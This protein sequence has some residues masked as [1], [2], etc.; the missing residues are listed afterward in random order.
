MPRNSPQAGRHPEFDA[1]ASKFFSA[2]GSAARDAIY[3]EASALAAQVGPVAT[4]YLRVMEKVANGSEDYI[5]KE[6]KRYVHV[7]QF[8]FESPNTTP[9]T[10]SHRSY[11]SASYRPKNWMRSRPRR[12]SLQRLLWRRQRKKH[13]MHSSVRLR[14]CSVTVLC[15][16]A[17][18]R[19][20]DRNIRALL[21]GFPFTASCGTPPRTRQ[22]S[23]RTVIMDI[24]R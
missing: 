15:M 10:V 13:G 12:T 22:V 17:R 16:W 19:C 1:L 6:T 23:I 4:H 21:P 24:R 11:K 7:I 3:K 20:R 2:I 5:A 18:T 9:F 8:R 14:I